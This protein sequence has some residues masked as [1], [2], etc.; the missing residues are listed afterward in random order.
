MKKS[1]RKPDQSK[2]KKTLH[3]LATVGE[4][5]YFGYMKGGVVEAVFG[6]VSALSKAL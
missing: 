3:T 1:I 5:I 2:R 6:G 4:A